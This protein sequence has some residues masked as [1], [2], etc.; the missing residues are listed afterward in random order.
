MQ[1]FTPLA[2]ASLTNFCLTV[3]YPG[4][5]ILIGL[6]VGLAIDKAELVEEVIISFPRS[7]L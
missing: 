6:I 1:L 3:E 2:F 4:K 7:F 5:G